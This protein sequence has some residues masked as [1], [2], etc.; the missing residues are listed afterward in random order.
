MKKLKV[1]MVVIESNKSD[2][3]VFRLI[4]TSM[5]DCIK[6]IRNIPN[7]GKHDFS[8]RKLRDKITDVKFHFMNKNIK[9]II[10]NNKTSYNKK[11]K[12]NENRLI[13]DNNK[14]LLITGEAKRIISYIHKTIKKVNYTQK[15][16]IILANNYNAVS[17]NLKIIK[18]ANANIII[19][20]EY[21]FNK[22]I[23]IYN[24]KKR[25]KLIKLF[26]KNKLDIK[27]FI[28]GGFIEFII[29]HNIELNINEVYRNKKDE[30]DLVSYNRKTNII[31]LSTRFK[32]V[33]KDVNLLSFST[34][35]ADIE[36]TDFCYKIDKTNN[37]L[38]KKEEE[39]K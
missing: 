28:V 13:S 14:V 35:T 11:K 23:K 30:I 34:I 29:N 9:S 22:K 32:N 2:D 38:E 3:N 37:Y 25:D 21:D 31:Y 20:S 39:T 6:N 5:K 19:Q 24:I 36:V 27:E 18:E 7:V 1:Y 26:G 16:E 15:D 8:I 33:S 10:L 4:G 12:I 17:R